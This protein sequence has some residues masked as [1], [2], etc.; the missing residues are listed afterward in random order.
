MFIEYLLCNTSLETLTV[1]WMSLSL[2]QVP[3]TFLSC[4]FPPSNIPTSQAFMDYLPGVD[5]KPACS[6]WFA[7]QFQ[8]YA[9][10]LL[11][12]PQTKL[13]ILPP[14]PNLLPLQCSQ[15]PD[16]ITLVFHARSLIMTLFS[17]LYSIQ[18]PNL[19]LL[20]SVPTFYC[21]SGPCLKS[22]HC[23]L[24]LRQF[25]TFFLVSLVPGPLYSNLFLIV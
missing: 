9:S 7:P 12:A 5:Y 24:L 25:K 17:S 21:N 3:F 11:N 4:T 23:Q 8:I 20:L 14:T 15:I 13:T 1:L 10:N 6:L 22:V 16:N 18:S 2:L 19:F